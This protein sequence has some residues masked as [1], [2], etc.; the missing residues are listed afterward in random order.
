MS[1]TCSLIRSAHLQVDALAHTAIRMYR[2]YRGIWSAGHCAEYGSWRTSASRG[3]VSIVSSFFVSRH[4]S[5]W[6]ATPMSLY[7]FQSCKEVRVNFLVPRALFSLFPLYL[8]VIG[9]RLKRHMKL[10][11]PLVAQFDDQVLDD[12]V[13]V[14]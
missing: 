10:G 14:W 5:G 9:A 11:S 6:W 2:R 3:G 13:E 8:Q 7:C 12:T 4:R 1:Q